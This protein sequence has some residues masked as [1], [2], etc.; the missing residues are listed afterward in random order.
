MPEGPEIRI[1]ADELHA[2]LAGRRTT[3][4]F[5]AFERLKRYEATLTG[6]VVDAV[7]SRGKAMLTRFAN[8]LVLYNHNQLYGDWYVQPAGDLLE[9]RRALRVVLTNGERSALLY[10]ATDIEVLTGRELSGHPYLKRLGPDVLDGGTGAREIAERFLEERFRRRQLAALLLDQGFVAGLGNYLRSEVLFFAGL[11]P[12][13]RPVDCSREELSRLARRTLEI[14]RR[15][16][17]TG[18]VTND[19]AR[20]AELEALGRPRAEYLHAAYGRRGEPCQVCG[21]AV[22]RIEVGS[23]G[24]YLCPRCQP[25]SL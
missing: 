12:R 15:S 21:T 14:A 17:E 24:C 11:H 2:A 23:R 1:S 8:G 7:E 22:E 25:S 16:Y 20:V 19:P 9:T 6:V 4:V 3:A 10:S 18:G 13:K 5:F